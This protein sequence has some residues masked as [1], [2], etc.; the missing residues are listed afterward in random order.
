MKSITVIFLLCSI[1][2]FS[3]A[4]LISTFE[5]G[6]MTADAQLPLSNS[7]S[8]A[9]RERGT[10]WFGTARGLTR[11]T[12]DGASWTHYASA[13]TFDDKGISA[14]AVR[15]D[16]IWVAIGYSERRD[17]S[18]IQIG[19]GLHFSTNRGTTWTYVK[20]PMDTGTVD[21]LVYGINKI[22][23]LA[24]TVPEQNLTFDIAMTRNTVW[25]A[26]FGGM[27][28]KSTDQGKTWQR[29]ILPPD[30]SRDRISP[31]DTLSFDLSPSSGRLGLQE[32]LNH[33]AFS[34]YASDDSTIWVG[35]SGGIN[36]STDGGIS[37]RKFT[38][39]NQS[40]PISGNW[41]VAINEQRLKGK[42][43]IWAATVNARDA[44]ERQGVSFSS[45]GGESWT[46]T[47][48]GERAHN[49]E[50][51]DSVVYVATNNGLFR[52]VDLGK[53][54]IRTGS[55][56]DVTTR[57]RFASP[58]IYAAATK[59][60]TLWISGSEG[61]AYTIDHPA[62]PFG[63]TWKI[64]RTYEPVGSSSRTY[65][66]PTPFSPDDEVVRIHYSTA[67]KTVP[68]TIRIFDFAMIPTRTLIQNATR[69][70]SIEHDEIWDG[71][72]DFNRRVANGVYF[73]RIDIESTESIWGKI[74]VVQ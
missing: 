42:R 67:D 54:W 69:I 40:R 11:T 26:S 60:D 14:I 35:T 45:D 71:R 55:I 37:W 73:Y 63:S 29:V 6:S 59:G 30:G 56:T 48:L 70:G 1:S 15:G 51:R 74:H 62:T 25:I 58:T 41:V 32:N 7:A 24:V 52:S 27:F 43:I 46:T 68:V 28:R 19:G 64:F 16:T 57:Q 53:A 12:D 20:Q 10:L 23:A 36:K 21:T 49:I 72:D 17:G 22:R 39:Q 18:T 50:F 33:I 66:F 34:A 3:N 5:L 9:A 44:S 38:A 8:V 2:V 65:A 47:L 13:Q 61:I 4:Q 31:T